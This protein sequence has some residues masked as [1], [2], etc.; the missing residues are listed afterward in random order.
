MVYPKLSP[1]KTAPANCREV[2][3][4]TIDSSKNVHVLIDLTPLTRN[5]ALRIDGKAACELARPR[6]TS[7]VSGGGESAIGNSLQTVR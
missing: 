7:R 2:Y 3:F 1:T 5:H 6:F 4:L